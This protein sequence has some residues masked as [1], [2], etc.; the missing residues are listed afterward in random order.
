MDDATP[1]LLEDLKSPDAHIREQATHQLWDNWFWQK[2][3]MG[4][5]ALRRSQELLEAGEIETAELILNDLIEQ[6]PDFAEAWNQRA[7]LFYTQQK[8]EQ[9]RQDCDHVI[10]LIPFHFGALHGLG[11]CYASLGDYREAIRAFRAALDV[12]PYALINQKL[13]LE[14]SAKL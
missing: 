14:C 2:G 6:Q 7:V 13:L 5:K 8:F 1:R 10:R 11:L 3:L 9:A 12:Q 4:L